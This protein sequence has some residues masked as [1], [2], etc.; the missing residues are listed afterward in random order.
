MSNSEYCLKNTDAHDDSN[1]SKVTCS[2]QSMYMYSVQC[3]PIVFCPI[4]KTNTYT[5]PTGTCRF[6]HVKN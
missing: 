1:F 3:R 6:V 5:V 4:D 2:L